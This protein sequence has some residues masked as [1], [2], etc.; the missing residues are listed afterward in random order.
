MQLLD[1]QLGLC[2]KEGEN[3]IITLWLHGTYIV[4]SHAFIVLLHGYFLPCKIKWYCLLKKSF[5]ALFSRKFMSHTTEWQSRASLLYTGWHWTWTGKVSELSLCQDKNKRR[6][7]Y[8]YT[9]VKLSQWKI[10]NIVINPKSR[11]QIS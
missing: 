5:P 4:N 2:F 10:K 6:K 11:R 3:W 1:F 8:I 9:Y 7:K